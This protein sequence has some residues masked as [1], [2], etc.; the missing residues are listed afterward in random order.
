MLRF[1]KEVLS[2][3]CA[4]VVAAA[5]AAAPQE[6]PPGGV[7]GGLPPVVGPT[8]PGH[9]PGGVPPGGPVP[10]GRGTGGGGRSVA[11]AR[12]KQQ[13][14]VDRLMGWDVWWEV[15]DD[16]FLRA[17]ASARTADA[18]ATDSDALLGAAGKNLVVKI[19]AADLDK[20]IVP[21][22]TRATKDRYVGVRRQAAMALGKVGNADQTAVFQSVK[23]VVADTD[24]EVRAAACLGLGLLGSADGVPLLVSIMKNDAL[25]K[26]FSGMGAHDFSPRERGFAALGVG[27]I[28]IEA[29]LRSEPVQEMMAVLSDNKIPHPDVRVFTALA[30]GVVH[31]YAAVPQLKKTAFDPAVAEVVR[32]HAVVA[33]GKLGDKSS[34]Q[35]FARE[36]LVDRSSHVQRSSAIALGLLTDREDQ[37]TVEAL[38]DQAKSSADRGVKNFALVALGQIGHKLGREHLRQQL[39]RGSQHDRTFAAMGLGVHGAKFEEGRKEIARDLLA[40]FAEARADAERGAFAI[41]LGLVDEKAAVEPVL[42]ALSSG[43]SPELRA[44]LATAAGL[45]GDKRAVPVLQDILQKTADPGLIMKA[46]IALGS[47]GDPGAVKL[48]VKIFEEAGNNQPALFGATLALGFIGDRSAVPPLLRALEGKDSHDYTRAYAAMALG[49]LGDKREPRTLSIVQENT[50]YLATTEWLSELLA[51]Y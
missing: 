48:L 25:G 23:A 37:R 21:A 26:S 12:S 9:A 10:R 18:Q 43:G 30:L 13:H 39:K 4:A 7:P 11:A 14:D 6:P 3:A 46:A 15:N 28:G 19:T 47:I 50:N 8:G 29:G 44:Q 40:A 49:V 51:L 45:L 1:M 20:E 31:A 16:R 35:L 24:W 32:A 36:G 41:A 5:A 42:L 38:V 33:L 27:I 22:L 34:V 2:C 17:R